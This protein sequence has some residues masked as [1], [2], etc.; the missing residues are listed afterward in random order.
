MPRGPSNSRIIALASLSLALHACDHPSE[1]QPPVRQRPDALASPQPAAP[2]LHAEVAPRFQSRPSGPRVPK[3]GPKPRPPWCPIVPESTTRDARGCFTAKRV[4]FGEHDFGVVRCDQGP[5]SFV[6]RRRGIVTYRAEVSLV[7]DIGSSWG[8]GGEEEELRSLLAKP[9]R[10]TNDLYLIR[11]YER[12]RAA[13][14]WLVPGTDFNG[15]GR[16]NLVLQDHHLGNSCCVMVH[17]FEIAPRFRHLASSEVGACT[18]GIF[19]DLD[20]DQVPELESFDCTLRGTYDHYAAGDQPIPRVVQRYLHG[21]FVLAGD[22]MRRPPLPEWLLRAEAEYMRQ[23]WTGTK[24]P[25]ALIRTAVDLIYSGRADQAYRLLDLAWRHCAPGSD[26]WRWHG[27]LASLEDPRVQRSLLDFSE[28][29]GWRRC[30]DH[31]NVFD[32]P[33]F[34][35][36]RPRDSRASMDSFWA[37]ILDGLRTSPHREEIKALNQGKWPALTQRARLRLGVRRHKGR[38]SE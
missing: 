31:A 37:Y 14:R 22:L 11:Q 9:D 36:R 10:D 27:F 34:E 1:P 12:E 25:A 29:V 15:D 5:S 24:P 16:P 30:V 28:A 2:R 13:L 32:A 6:V 4:R 19:V 3:A 21:R 26:D 38:T 23:H 20:D 35:I 7:V 17:L 8:C 33:V 18:G